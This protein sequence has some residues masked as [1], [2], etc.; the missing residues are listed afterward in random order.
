VKL[1]QLLDGHYKSEPSEMPT[2][3]YIA[4]Q[5]NLSPNYLSDMLRVHTGQSTQQ[6]IRNKMIALAKEKLTSTNLSVSEIAYGLGFEHVQS[7]NR[8]FKSKTNQSPLEY[9]HR[10]N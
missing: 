2:V 4:N 3:Q 9:K 6:H 8:M 1:E 5:L 7:F 10:F